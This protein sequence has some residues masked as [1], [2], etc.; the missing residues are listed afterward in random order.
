MTRLKVHHMADGGTPQAVIAAKCGIS[1]RSVERVLGEPEPTR[2]EVAAD[3]RSDQRRP[4]RPRIVRDALL[5]RIRALVTAEPTIAATEVHRRARG[6][7]YTGSRS[8]MAALVK[9]LRPLPKTE[10]IVRFEGLA[11]EYAQFDFGEAKVT[12]EDGTRDKLIF[13]AARLKYS[14]FMH[15]L[16][17]RD[18]TAETLARSLVASLVAFGGAP[19]EWV[20]DNPKTVRISAIG[21]EPPVLHPY[22]RDL[23]AEHRAIPTLCTPGKGQQKGSVERLV[24]FAKRS[25]FFARKFRDRA[26][27]EAQLVEWLYEVNHTRPCDATGVIPAVALRDE[28]PWLAERPVRITPDSWTMRET[29]TVTPTGT[30]SFAGTPYFATARRIGA[31]ATL[32]VRRHEVEIVVG[33]ER[34]VHRRRDGL[35]VVQMLP[36]QRSDLLAAVHGRRK[37]ATARREALLRV[38]KPAWAFLTVLTHRHPDGRWERPCD[39][40]YGLLE[41]HGDEAMLAAFERCVL[42]HRY[43]VDDVVAALV[44][45]A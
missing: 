5:E 7:G 45:V 1:L 10:L 18:Q 41:R 20:F 22:L 15:V 40:L 43:T 2:E 23:V 21:V 24:K 27:A 3:E 33:D 6:W 25:F 44:E 39:D 4:G 17:V 9:A 14:R 34:V 29:A 32:F 42:H 12:Y 38:G 13:W 8:T 30:I 16:V 11:G 35:G 26:D 28:A 19:K 36:S 31:P 37:K